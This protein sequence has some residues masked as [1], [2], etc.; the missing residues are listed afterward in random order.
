VHRHT[1]TYDLY[2]DGV[3][4]LIWK[5]VHY[6]E[7]KFTE[8]N[9]KNIT[10]LSKKTNITNLLAHV[11]KLCL[12]GRNTNNTVLPATCTGSSEYNISTV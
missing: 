2:I 9:N 3:S 5:N 10:K 1:H 8:S 11:T 4:K 12:L 6:L 7:D